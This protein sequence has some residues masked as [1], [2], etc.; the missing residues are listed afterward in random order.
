MIKMV[1][2]KDLMQYFHLGTSGGKGWDAQFPVTE[3]HTINSIWFERSFTDRTS[4]GS[5]YP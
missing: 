5:K 1:I 4:A 3:S 2:R